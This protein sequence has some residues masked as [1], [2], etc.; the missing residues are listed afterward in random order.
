V[1]HERTN[2]AMA[3]ERTNP[4]MNKVTRRVFTNTPFGQ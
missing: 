3:H 2:P 1:A 4:T